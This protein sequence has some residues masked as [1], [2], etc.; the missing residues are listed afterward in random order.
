[1]GEMTITAEMTGMY[2]FISGLFLLFIP[3][4]TAVTQIKT[5]APIINQLTTVE[6]IDDTISGKFE[7]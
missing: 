7:N 3:I 1:M 2:P 5:M 4:Q 6:D